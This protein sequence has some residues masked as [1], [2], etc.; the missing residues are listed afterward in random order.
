VGRPQAD[1]ARLIEFL[2]SPASAMCTGAVLE[3]V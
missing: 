1:V 2:G 3:A